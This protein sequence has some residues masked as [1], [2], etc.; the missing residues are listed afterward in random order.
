[1]SRKEITY[2]RRDVYRT[3]NPRTSEFQIF[4]NENETFNKIHIML[5]DKTSLSKL[6]RSE[7]I[8]SL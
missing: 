7:V 6:E 2:Y 5:N 8:I 1:M 3:S 4:S